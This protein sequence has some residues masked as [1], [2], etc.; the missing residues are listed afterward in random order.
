MKI[1]VLNSIENQKYLQRYAKRN[2]VG[3]NSIVIFLA[4]NK[5]YMLVITIFNFFNTNS[6]T[7]QY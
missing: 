4:D 5:T 6:Y 3:I 7:C 2:A 1:E